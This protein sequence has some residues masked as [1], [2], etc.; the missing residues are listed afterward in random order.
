MASMK[1]AAIIQLY[2]QPRIVITHVTYALASC[3]ETVFDLL[4]Y[5]T[6]RGLLRIRIPA[7]IGIRLSH[8]TF[9][10]APSSYHHECLEALAASC[11]PDPDHAVPERRGGPGRVANKGH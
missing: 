6:M 8:G 11:A 5:D 3:F 7:N 2:M 9:N 4:V 1:H 10:Q